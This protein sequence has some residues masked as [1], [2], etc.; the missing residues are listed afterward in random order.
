MRYTGAT[1]G[2][3][4]GEWRD[5]SFTVWDALA[6]YNFGQ[7]RL[8][9]NASNLFDKTYVVQCSA[10]TTCYYGV[11]RDVTASLTRAF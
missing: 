7:W 11:P 6:H 10:F 1:F 4:A 8:Q 5:P 3:T 2:D 9:V